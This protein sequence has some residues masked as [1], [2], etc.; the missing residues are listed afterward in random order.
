MGLE[1]WMVL[2]GGSGSTGL[3]GLMGGGIRPKG[4][5]RHRFRK[6]KGTMNFMVVWL[7]L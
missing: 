4:T 1:G 6:R 2:E 5:A 7:A 3:E